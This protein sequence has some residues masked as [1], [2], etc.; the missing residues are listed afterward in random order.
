MSKPTIDDVAALAGVARTT[1]SRVLN[2]QPNVREE[3]RDKVMRA[4]QM[5]GYRVNLQARH[6]AGRKAMRLALVHASDF[7]SEPNSYFS[8]ALELG[9][10]RASA[11]IGAQLITHVVNQ[12]DPGAAAEVIA[13]A[14]D[15]QCDGII[16]T[17][18]FADDIE[19]LRALETMQ[20][21]VVAIAAGPAS[22]GVVATLGIDDRQAGYDIGAH[23]LAMGHRRFAFIKGLQGHLSAET[24]FDGFVQ[25]LH[26][27]GIGADTIV[28]ERGNF[29]FRSGL[30]CAQR[31]LDGTQPITALVCANDD[32]AAGALLAAHKAGLQI[33]QQIA[34]TGFDDT[35]VSEIVWPPL[36]TIHQPLRQMGARA[37]ELLAE[38]IGGAQ[39]DVRREVLD[40]SLVVRDSSGAG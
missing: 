31:L 35:P 28:L 26:D 15:D 37:V 30:D 18:P 34:I 5:L 27:A 19:L 11:R 23:L 36:T 13:S 22:D 32:M 8:S 1:V 24:R 17:P 2:H 25:A 14:S 16:L 38:L 7:D 10:T 21:R 40:H 29:T 33:P 6:L 4:V 12:N 3:V 20:C 9:A 39:Q